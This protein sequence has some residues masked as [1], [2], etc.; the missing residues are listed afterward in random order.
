MWSGLDGVFGTEDDV[1]LHGVADSTGHLTFNG[2]PGGSFDCQG[3]DPTSGKQSAKKSVV[4]NVGNS[5]PVV[6]A[7]PIAKPRR[8]VFTVSGFPKG[9]P[10]MTKAMQARILKVMKLHP[11]AKRVSIIGYTMGPTVLKV[12]YKL[13][14]DRAKAAWVRVKAV[15]NL[16]R[17]ISLR[18]SQVKKKTGSFIRRVTIALYF[19]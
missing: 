9:S 5:V 18:S 12:D 16:S 1:D 19:D 10:K 11:G 8:Y 4:V 15:D 6:V 13:S 3:T 17:L 14:M 2:L 7:L